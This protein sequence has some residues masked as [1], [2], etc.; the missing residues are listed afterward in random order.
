MDETL[1]PP[2]E[3][4]QPPAPSTIHK[5]FLGP[6]GLRAGWSA[7]IFVAVFAACATIVNLFMHFVVHHGQPHT[8]TPP[9]VHGM[10][11]AEII[12]V[13]FVV[14][15]T[16]V[17]ARI[18]KRPFSAYGLAGTRRAPLFTTGLCWGFAFISLLVGSL[19]FTH[20]ISFDPSHA[21]LLPALKYGAVWA[22]I[23]ILVG[24]FEEMLLRG[25]LL[26]TIWRGIGFW[27]AAVILS[28][29]FG[30]LH[31]RN[32]E[33]SPIGL[34]SAGAVGLVFC[35]SIWYTRSLWW[36]IG[37]HAAW[38]WGQTFFYG[39]SDSGLP[40]KGSFFVTHPQGSLLMSGGATGPEGSLLILPILLLI[41]LVIY[42]TLRSHPTPG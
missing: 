16:W 7:L 1:T 4:P 29:T 23:F 5:I 6:Q 12:S 34:V 36:A 15:A 2:E 32:P 22:I 8:H 25:Y 31:G 13:I 41:S 17:M 24:F 3:Q 35:L 33:E 11:I 20:H 40:A 26:W 19:Y 21:A 18:E 28:F 10:L 39:A 27:W 9:T 14:I 42:L 38:N 30:A 37:F